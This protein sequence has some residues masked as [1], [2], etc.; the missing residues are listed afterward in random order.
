MALAQFPKELFFHHLQNDDTPK[1]L[2]QTSNYY[3]FRDSK[4][5]IWIGSNKGLNCFNGRSTKIYEPIIGDSTSMLGQSIQGHFSEDTATANLW[6][7]TYAAVNCLNRETGTFSAY[8]IKKGKSGYY[9]GGLDKS[10]H[11]WVLN[12]GDLYQFDIQEKQFKKVTG[13]GKNFSRLKIQLDAAGKVQRVFIWENNESHLLVA[14][15]KEDNLVSVDT[16]DSIFKSYTNQA[17]QINDVLPEQDSL[18]WIL[19]NNHLWKYNFLSKQI[20]YYQPDKTIM[21]VRF[22]GLNAVDQNLFALATHEK[23]LLFFDKKTAQFSKPFKANLANAY[24]ISDNNIGAVYVDDQSVLW[25][26]ADG[27]GIDFTSLNKTKFESY[28]TLNQGGSEGN[29]LSLRKIIHLEE[30]E[31]WASTTVH[32]IFVLNKDKKIIR[33]INQQNYPN[34]PSNQI[35]QLLQDNQG[36]IWIFTW[37]GLVLYDKKSKKIYPTSFPEDTYFEGI[38]IQDGRIIFSTYQ[39]G[40]VILDE[41]SEEMQLIPIKFKAEGNYHRIFGQDTRQNLFIDND[42]ETI[43]IIDL[44]DSCRVLKTIPVTGKCLSF[45]EDPTTNFIWVGTKNGLYQITKD[46]FNYQIYNKK[47]G[48]INSTIYG[49]LPDG[50]NNLWLAT[51]FGIIRFNPVTLEIKAFNR[52]DGLSAME[53]NTYA[54]LKKSDGE[55]WFGS[56]DG[57]TTFYPENIQATTKPPTIQ[58]TQIL[59][60]DEV[61]PDL[62]DAQ[63]KATNVSEIQQLEMA[64][65]DNTLSF[66][67]VA[68]DYADPS[69]NQFKYR[70]YGLEENWVNAGTNGFARYPNLPSGNYTFQVLAANSDGIWTKQ[71][72]GIN[73]H[74][75]TPFWQTQWFQALMFGSLIFLVWFTT[76][77]YRKRK[78]RIRNLQYEKNIVNEKLKRAASEQ[79]LLLEEERLRIAGNLHDDLGSQL[80]ALQ[81]QSEVLQ[82]KTPDKKLSSEL[83]SFSK[84][85]KD[86]ANKVN[87]AIWVISSRNDHLHKLLG[88]LHAYAAEFFEATNI[89]CT[90]RL[91]LDIPPISIVGSTRQE[92]LLTF[93][94]ML[95]N[96][97]KHSA[98]EKVRIQFRIDLNE[99]A[100][101]VQDTGVGIDQENLKNQ[102]GHGLFSMQQRMKK[103]DGRFQIHNLATGG[104]EAIIFFPI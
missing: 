71:P 34:L 76:T 32:G 73:I 70:M 91:P 96:V 68:L 104:A 87:E 56:V 59:V 1:S 79:Q 69:K 74:I 88:Y 14:N 39:Q 31:I 13:F 16:L 102:Q 67:F 40:N 3:V 60:G 12:W 55:I 45:Y 61:N 80:S 99:V 36:R 75:A 8:Q 15:F 93:K 58:I 81:L 78:E 41:S 90:V 9:S 84:F 18:T 103:I 38:Q 44:L 66:D 52:T 5:L 6:F 25:A 33:R 21:P 77:T 50:K 17:I 98:A 20:T 24:S 46:S 97:L 49:I 43:L 23:G 83:Q 11:F 101:L 92:V 51:D 100:I 62:A 30:N 57:I 22:A 27:H 86:L 7:C 54:Y 37:G 29:R 85:S 94:E 47:N 10:G 89:E 42:N 64:Y 65:Y 4:D 48:L 26:T 82:Y 53:F 2:S 35:N 72:K 63:T 28:L 95:N 19:D